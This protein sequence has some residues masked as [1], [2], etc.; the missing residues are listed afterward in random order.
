MSNKTKRTIILT[1]K[2]HPDALTNDNFF[3]RDDAVVISNARNALEMKQAKQVN[4]KTNQL[5]RFLAANKALV[6]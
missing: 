2:K 6:S 3:T 5:K 4:R 1:V